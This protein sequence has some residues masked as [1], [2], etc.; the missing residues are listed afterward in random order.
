VAEAKNSHM[1]SSCLYL[2]SRKLGSKGGT[3]NLKVG[4]YAFEKKGGINALEGVGQCIGRWGSM[5]SKEGGGAIQQK[6]KFEKGGVHDPPPSPSS[7]VGTATARKIGI[8]R[9]NLDLFTI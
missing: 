3:T 8:H 5:Y 7:Y 9:Y 4:I 2:R 1:T 6:Q